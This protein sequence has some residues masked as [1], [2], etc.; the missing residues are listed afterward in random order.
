M[1]VRNSSSS[2]R[3][4]RAR[5]PVVFRLQTAPAALPGR[6]LKIARTAKSKT[7][8]AAVARVACSNLR[9]FRSAHKSLRSRRRRFVTSPRTFA[10]MVVI[11]ARTN[12]EMNYP[13]RHSNVI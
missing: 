3:E 6:Q 13:Y 12:V 8:E 5:T 2:Y 10:M 11:E 7:T 4:G 1:L 9:P